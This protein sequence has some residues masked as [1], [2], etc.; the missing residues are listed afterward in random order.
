MV[1]ALAGMK[2]AKVG[3]G[4]TTTTPEKKCELEMGV[5]DRKRTVAF[6]DLPGDD[7]DF[8][9]CDMGVVTFVASLDVLIVLYHDTIMYTNR[10]ARI[11]LALG[12]RLIF[13][14]NKVEPHPTGSDEDDERTWQEEVAQDKA[15]LEKMLGKER[16]RSLPVYGVS[17]ANAWQAVKRAQEEAGMPDGTFAPPLELFD[18]EDFRRTLTNEVQAIP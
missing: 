6:Y 9:Y 1:N 18:W 3:K 15:H 5:G 2:V 8:E 7:Q 13:L 14:R 4:R 10:I 12:K 11:G 16:A 17:T